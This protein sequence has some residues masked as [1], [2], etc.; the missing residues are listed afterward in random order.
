MN[1]LIDHI[2]YSIGTFFPDSAPDMCR[3]SVRVKFVP[4]GAI[5]WFVFN[6]QSGWQ[7]IP[8]FNPHKYTGNQGTA[9][10]RFLPTRK[11]Y[12]TTG[13]EITY[14]HGDCDD[15]RLAGE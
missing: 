15:C 7:P 12:L 13:E 10:G 4:S 8:G 3:G 9:I 14:R 5:H 6:T 11:V 2:E 1:K